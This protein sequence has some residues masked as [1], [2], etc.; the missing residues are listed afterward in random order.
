M[1]NKQLAI[2]LRIAK[3]LIALE[4]DDKDQFERYLDKHPGANKTD[5]TVKG[6]KVNPPPPPEVVKE[7]ENEQ[8]DPVARMNK[9]DNF[10]GLTKAETRA[11]SNWPHNDKDVIELTKAMDDLKNVWAKGKFETDE[12]KMELHKAITRVRTNY[13]KAKRRFKSDFSGR[14]IK[15]DPE[16]SVMAHMKPLL[17]K[18]EINHNSDEIRE[19]VGFKDKIKKY[20]PLNCDITF[21][22]NNRGKLVKSFIDNMD[23]ENYSSA[24]AFSKA[25]SKIKNMPVEDVIKLLSILSAKKELEVNPEDLAEVEAKDTGDDKKNHPDSPS[26]AAKPSKPADPKSGQGDKPKPAVAAPKDPYTVEKKPFVKTENPKVVKPEERLEIEKPE[27][28]E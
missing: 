4:F 20:I 16:D 22:E 11:W 5:H 21:Y 27:K 12:A 19:M 8:G 1:T 24:E 3:I 9:A 6:K 18:H 26:K 28:P 23:P 7:N 2:N 13:A 17:D 10:Y 14:H 25:K 15:M